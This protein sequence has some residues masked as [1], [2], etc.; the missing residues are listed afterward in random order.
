MFLNQLSEDNKEFFL[1]LCLHASMADG[2]FV[3]EEMASVS[4]YCHEMMIPNH[5]PNEEPLETVLQKINLT[6]TA[7]E[8]KIIV[9]EIIMLLKSDDDYPKAEKEFVLKV[10]RELGISVEK[11]HTLE[12]LADIY[13]V[14]HKKLSEEVKC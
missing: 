12:T 4:L 5:I 14:V 10:V 8:K 11:Y 2:E 9:L 6:A 13:R 3:L 7:Q 1:E